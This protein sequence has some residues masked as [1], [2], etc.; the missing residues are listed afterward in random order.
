VFTCIIYNYVA[1][2]G[3]SQRKTVAARPKAAQGIAAEIL[4]VHEVD[5]KIGAES[6]VFGVKRQKC[7]KIPNR[8]EIING[9]WKSLVF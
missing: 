1:R 3:W 8:G 7:G 5:K 6:P 2:S 9:F 4:F